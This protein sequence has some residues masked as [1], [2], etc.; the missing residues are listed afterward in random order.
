MASAQS[1]FDSK[2]ICEMDSTSTSTKTSLKTGMSGRRSQSINQSRSH[3]GHRQKYACWC[4]NGHY[5]NALTFVDFNEFQLFFSENVF[6]IQYLWTVPLHN[7]TIVASLFRFSKQLHKAST[8]TANFLVRFQILKSVSSEISDLFL[9]A[10]YF[11]SQSKGIHFGDYFFDVC[12]KN[13]S[14]W[15]NVR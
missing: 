5:T 11:T 3:Q 14:V 10:S 15:F 13:E 2:E 12:C 8:G 6:C 9:N 1:D 7:P 4:H